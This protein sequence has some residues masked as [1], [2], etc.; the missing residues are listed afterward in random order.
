MLPFDRTVHAVRNLKISFLARYAAVGSAAALVYV[1]LYYGLVTAAQ[2]PSLLSSCFAFAVSVIVQYTA[3]A[4][5]S[6]G[7]QVVDLRQ[8]VRFAGATLIGLAASSAIAFAG[9]RIGWPP[10]L[11]AAVVV[12]FLPPLNLA[13]L[14]G[15]VFAARNAAD[16]EPSGAN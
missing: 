11:T 14:A 16:S 2:A 13:L 10:I 3:H 6:F 4:R 12:T 1:G 9:P 7:S 5:F 15:W 8:G